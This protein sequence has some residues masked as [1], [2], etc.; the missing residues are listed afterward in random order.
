MRRTNCKA[1]ALLYSYDNY[2]GAD[3]ELLAIGDSEQALSKIMMS[4]VK[5]FLQ[6]NS[7]T[8][9]D[10]DLSDIPDENDPAPTDAKFG[11]YEGLLSNTWCWRI[12]SAEWIGQ[13]QDQE[14]SEE[15]SYINAFVFENSFYEEIARDQLR[16]L[17][18][19]YCLHHGLDADTKG[20]D[21]DLSRIWEAICDAE[22]DTADWSV[23]ESF[24]QFMCRYLV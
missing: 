19:A 15:L 24:Q 10:D 7:E 6:N 4:E 18:T 11:Y 16:I 1:Y 12:R 17:W 22:C 8:E 2:D 13:S 14:R 5:K 9:W 21:D 3:I 23:Y 20:Y